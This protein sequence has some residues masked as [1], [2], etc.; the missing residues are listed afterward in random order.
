MVS[1]SKENFAAALVLSRKPI[2]SLTDSY[3]VEIKARPDDQRFQY[4]IK[5]VDKPCQFKD[6]DDLGSYQQVRLNLNIVIIN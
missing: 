1:G 4:C 3:T 5:S 2:T 6:S